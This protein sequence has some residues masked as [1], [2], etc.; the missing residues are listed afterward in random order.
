MAVPA[1]IQK[2]IQCSCLAIACVSYITQSP[3]SAV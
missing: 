2:L 3:V 1:A